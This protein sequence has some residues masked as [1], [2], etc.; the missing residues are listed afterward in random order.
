[1]SFKTMAYKYAS[2]LLALWTMSATAAEPRLDQALELQKRQEQERLQRRIDSAPAL[3]ESPAIIPP[4]PA[5]DAGTCVQVS[6]IEASGITLLPPSAVQAALAP[7]T[8]KC[9]DAAGINGVLESLNN[10]YLQ[11]G[12]VTARAYLPEQQVRD[13]LLTLVVI[14]GRIES[15]VL[16]GDAR[17]ADRRRRWLAIP[18]APGD[19][20][21]LADIEQGVDQLNRAP[22]AQATLALEPGSEPGMTRVAISTA[23]D[24][25]WR[26]GLSLDNNGEKTTGQYKTTATLDKDNFLEANDVWQLALS[27]TDDTR[28]FSVSTTLPVRYWTLTSSYSQSRYTNQLTG[29]TRLSGDSQSLLLSADYLFLRNARHQL[30]LVMGLTDKESGRKVAG[31]SLQPDESTPARMGLRW[32]YREPA[33]T[34]F[35]QA[36]WVRG[37]DWLGAT[38]DPSGLPDHFPHR[39]FDKL[40]LQGQYNRPLGAQWRYAAQLQAQFAAEGLIGN[41]QMVLGG[42]DSIRGFNTSSAFGDKG[43]SLRNQLATGC[44]TGRLPGLECQ[45]FVD[46]GIVRSLMAPPVAQL[47][48]GGAGLRLD[49]RHG[50]AEAIVAAPLYAS[51]GIDTDNLEFH[52]QVGLRY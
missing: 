11:Q 50:Y 5:A 20:L 17:S 25:S 6:R 7:H 9:L 19:M 34:V 31:V 2:L 14:E 13:G 4:A 43:V 30:S 12:Y 27:H 45:F 1:M 37:T 52:F 42:L 3:P 36:S 51:D 16:N 26:A 39:Q 10:A 22:S 35:L 29:G 28:A 23:D 18:A 40:E 32:L 48:G 44:F 46:G 47:L 15:I 33:Q 41:E 49:R 38:E 24:R 8:G 21:R